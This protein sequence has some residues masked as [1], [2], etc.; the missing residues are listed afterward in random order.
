MSHKHFEVETDQGITI[1]KLTD[2][3]LLDQLV[4]YEMQNELVQFL[5][6]EKPQRLIVSF[7]G[8]RR[9]S[10]EIINSMLRARKRVAAEGG[11]MRLCSMHSTIRDVFRMLNLEGNVFEIF[12]ALPPAKEGFGLA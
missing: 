8:V 1:V 11:D 6:Q 5:E 3:E 9:C 7:D 10:T 4:T 12:D 2:F